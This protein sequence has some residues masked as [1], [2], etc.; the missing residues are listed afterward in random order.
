M[1]EVTPSAIRSFY[2]DPREESTSLSWDSRLCSFLPFS[3]SVDLGIARC[4]VEDL[5]GGNK[6]V[7]AA[8]LRDVFGGQ[9]GAVADALVCA[10]NLHLIR[11]HFTP[12]VLTHCRC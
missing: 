6:E 4:T 2:V 10:K 8:I 1:L 3:L 7:N 9:R 12:K 11:S 5:R